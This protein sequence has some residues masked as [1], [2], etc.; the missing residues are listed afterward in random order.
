VDGD[1]G[2]VYP[3]TTA[4]I[5]MN[6]PSAINKFFPEP[7]AAQMAAYTRD[8]LD[9]KQ[10]DPFELVWRSAP[11]AEFD[12]CVIVTVDEVLRYTNSTDK[13]TFLLVG[14]TTDLTS[15]IRAHVAQLGSVQHQ[16]EQK[17]IDHRIAN[18]VHTA[19]LFVQDQKPQEAIAQLGH[20][21][22]LID[23]CRGRRELLSTKPV[24]LRALLS[25]AFVHRFVCE[26]GEQT[27]QFLAENGLLP[28]DLLC[29][30]ILDD[31]AS[32]CYEYGNATPVRLQVR[33][34]AAIDTALSCVFSTGD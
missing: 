16:T 8:I 27:V 21:R 7:C 15:L 2:C 25:R 23:V 6:D 18:M 9:G 34:N 31:I 1:P 10:S 30:R 32:I 26:Q 4:D 5:L 29:Y 14:H 22:S 12:L 3:G 24:V 20:I 28:P 13:T 11:D 33:L 17:L 19:S